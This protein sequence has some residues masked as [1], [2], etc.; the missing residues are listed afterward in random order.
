MSSTQRIFER[1]GGAPAPRVDSTRF[2]GKPYDPIYSGLTLHDFRRECS[3]K[4]QALGIP[5]TVIMSMGGWKTRSLFTRYAIVDETDVVDA[6]RRFESASLN[7]A[8]M[9]QIEGEVASK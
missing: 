9:V 4:S 2:D 7:G 5:E 1:N 3:A 6:M 8:K